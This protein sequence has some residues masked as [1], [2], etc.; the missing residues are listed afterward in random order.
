M[1]EFS[2]C[3]VKTFTV[4]SS[5]ISKKLSLNGWLTFVVCFQWWSYAKLK[6]VIPFHILFKANSAGIRWKIQYQVKV[7]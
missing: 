1:Y 4:E 3:Q 6:I 5:K 2:I 7:F